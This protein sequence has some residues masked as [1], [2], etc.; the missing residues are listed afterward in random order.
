MSNFDNVNVTHFESDRFKGTITRI[1]PGG[2]VTVGFRLEAEETATG[3]KLEPIVKKTQGEIYAFARAS[4][5]G[6]R[7][8][9]ADQ[10]QKDATERAQL[11]AM[12]DADEL[13]TGLRGRAAQLGITKTAAPGAVATEGD[14]SATDR[15]VL[16][17]W[18]KR[19]PQAEFFAVPQTT[20]LTDDHRHLGQVKRKAHNLAQL[21]RCLAAHPSSAITVENLDEIYK[22]LEY[23]GC[24]EHQDIRHRAQGPTFGGQAFEYEASKDPTLKRGKHYTDAELAAARRKLVM[25]GFPM[26]S[27]ITVEQATKALGDADLAQALFEE[28]TTKK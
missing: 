19:D 22:L 5:P 9:Q 27:R 1:C 20:A 16:D 4:M 21:G 12:V 26:T 18:M 2:I 23:M 10:E 15:L 3:K 17:G 7:V 6:F 11:Q 14:L 13:P 28:A 25:S 24:I 8:V